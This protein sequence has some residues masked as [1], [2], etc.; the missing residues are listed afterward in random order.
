MRNN[1]MTAEERDLYHNTYVEIDWK[2][3]EG[4]INNIHITS[5][6]YVLCII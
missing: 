1:K 3:L 2:L 5:R 6:I 4:K